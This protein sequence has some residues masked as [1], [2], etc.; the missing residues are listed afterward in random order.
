MMVSSERA[1]AAAHASTNSAI[2]AAYRARRYR[3]FPAAIRRS[4][5]RF[6]GALVIEPPDVGED[7][8]DLAVAEHRTERRHGAR[9]APLDALDDEFIAALG[10]RQ[11]RPPAGGATAILVTKA[12]GG[13]E[14]LVPINVVRQ[15][16]P[17]RLR[18]SRSSSA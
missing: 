5:C 12:A 18:P 6:G 10:L 2:V 14:H 9:L 7:R 8:D 11:F 4:P 3:G 13:G 1:S 15:A 16:L 17:L